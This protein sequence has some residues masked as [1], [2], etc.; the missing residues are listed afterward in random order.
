VT[1][2]REQHGQT[3]PATKRRMHGAELSDQIRFTIIVP[4]YNRR[5]IVLS[6]LQALAELERPWPCEVVVVDDG[7]S[8]GTTEAVRLLQMPFPYH[9]LTQRNS[10]AAAARNLGAQRATG[11]FLLFLDD[12]MIADRRL[13]LEHARVLDSGAD[14]VVGH[15]PLAPDA[16]ASVLTLGVQR[17]AE[18]RLE[19]LRSVGDGPLPVPDLL[20]GQLSVRAEVFR[21]AGGFDTAFTAGGTFGGEDVD[22]LYRLVRDGAKV[23][24]APDAVSWQRYVVTPKAHLRQW[25]EGGR[26]DAHLTRTHPALGTLVSRQHHG[27]TL[28]GGLTRAVA[29]VPEGLRKP[30]LAPGVS[31]ASVGRTDRVTRALFTLA[32]DAEYWAGV[33]EGG[34]LTREV[35]HCTVL[36][37][38]AIEDV[39][40]PVF[41][42]YSVGPDEFTAQIHALLEAG[43]EF[44]DVDAYLAHLEGAPLPSRAVLLTFDDGYASVHDAAAPV[45]RELGIPGV[46][47][48]VSSQIAGSNV[49]DGVAGAPV[50]P[51]MD[52]EQVKDLLAQGWEVGSHSRTHAHLVTLDRDRLLSEVA[53]SRQDLEELGIPGVR[54]LA[55]P[56][57]EHHFRVRAAARSAGYRAAFALAAPSSNGNRYSLSRVEVQRGEAPEALVSRMGEHAVNA[58]V[59]Q[60]RRE[61][62]GALGTLRDSFRS[63]LQRS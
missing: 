46:A 57:G 22:F 55:F 18:R 58:L 13:L 61:V 23:K 10:G 59:P 17:W 1:A 33:R 12:D 53:G 27:D 48:L 4:T 35:Q 14:A 11:E 37:Y 29:R 50:L 32:R 43:F 19:R 16:P 49:W 9:V 40:D 60:L 56:H 31:R 38:H 24:A 47:F 5:E 44:V 45:M 15:I 8:D 28:L 30:L 54:L 62:R 36:A 42:K 52:M 2:N 41:G 26:A 21:R 3:L 6:C 51:L 25:R 34:G 7:S 39:A 63:S 20:T